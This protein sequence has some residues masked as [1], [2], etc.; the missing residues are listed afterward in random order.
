MAAKTKFFKVST[1]PGTLEADAFYFVENGNY[2]E[3]Y[4]T[5]SAGV[6]RMIGNSNMINALIDNKLAGLNALEI[7]AD[8]TAR[9]A[10][11][12]SANAMVLV[13]D[14]SG[15]STVD[16]GA[17]LYAYDKANDTFTKVSEYESMDVVVSWTNIQGRPTS[18]PSQIDQAVAN[19]HTHANKTN[20]DKISEDAD[21]E[22]T[23]DGEP[24]RRWDTTN[25]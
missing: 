5:N 2:A 6:A 19:S 3:S 18:T 22:I 9:D 12:L 1:L 4:V 25:W 17:A 23:Y 13:T 16:S 20:L 7:V 21:G 15:D 8:I 11:T 10:L 14:A 24:V